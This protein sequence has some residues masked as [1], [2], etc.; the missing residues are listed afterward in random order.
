MELKEQIFTG[1]CN[2]GRGHMKESKDDIIFNALSEAKQFIKN[3]RHYLHDE[4]H[5]IFIKKKLAEMIYKQLQ[6]TKKLP[7]SFNDEAEYYE[8]YLEENLTSCINAV[9]LAELMDARNK[10]C[11]F[12]ENKEFCEKCQVTCLINDA[13]TEHGEE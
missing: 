4:I 6:D 11:A 5:R 12:C 9:K 3:V 13:Y 7:D 8:N 2:G 1:L 10:L